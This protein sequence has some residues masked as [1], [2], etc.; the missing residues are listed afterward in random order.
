MVQELPSSITGNKCGRG[1]SVFGEAKGCVGV[2]SRAWWSGRHTGCI[3]LVSRA[4]K[5]GRHKGC[6]GL[7]S[8]AGGMMS[9]HLCFGL[10]LKRLL[11]SVSIFLSITA[12]IISDS[13]SK[14]QGFIRS[15]VYPEWLALISGGA[16]RTHLMPFIICFE[17]LSEAQES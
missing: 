14:P 17:L 15:F 3:G 4:W 2:V 8:R 16:L 9:P 7:V 13:P 6:V 1:A 10:L 11:Y 5:S 12:E